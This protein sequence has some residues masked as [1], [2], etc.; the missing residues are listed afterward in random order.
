[1]KKFQIA[2]VAVAAAL[3]ITP[4]AMATPYYTGFV[5]ITDQG[6]TWNSTSVTFSGAT[7]I[8][9]I[10]TGSL[11]I[12]DSP[13]EAVEPS[14]IV[15]ASASG[16]V[17]SMDG[18]AVIFTINSLVQGT[19]SGTFLNL[20]GTGT[21]TGGAFTATPATWAL[22]ENDTGN[23]GFGASPDQA[24]GGFTI[25]AQN[26]G[27]PEPSSLLLLG[28]GLLGLALVAFRKTKTKTSNLTLSL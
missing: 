16:D 14:S 6:A 1:M 11:S 28:T 2:L 12:V 21:L 18:G 20:S 27:V 23:N 4:A 5:S 9:T 22:S 26:P 25:Q 19:D 8:S 13:P 15:F 10:G 24:A 3:A 7:V 17:I